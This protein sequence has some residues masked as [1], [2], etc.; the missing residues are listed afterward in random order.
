MAGLNNIEPKQPYCIDIRHV[1]DFNEDGAVD[2][3]DVDHLLMHDANAAK[4]L[5]GTGDFR[6]DECVEL[7]KQADIVV[8]NPP[9]SLFR[10]YLAQ[11]MDYGISTFLMLANP[12]GCR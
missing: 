6:S 4:P 11:L 8:T 12:N 9:F 3:S 2:L 10:K 7:L 5:E 1:D